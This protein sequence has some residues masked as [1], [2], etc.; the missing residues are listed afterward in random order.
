MG[1]GAVAVGEVGSV[2]FSVQFS[3]QCAVGSDVVM[4]LVAFVVGCELRRSQRY[5]GEKTAPDTCVIINN[6]ISSHLIIFFVCRYH[7]RI[8]AG[9]L[10]R[11][12]LVA[13]T[14]HNCKET[15]TCMV[16]M[17]RICIWHML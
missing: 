12:V 8:D 13:C 2:Q 16:A 6:T 7:P 4:Q 10:P 17:I 15:I 3:V 5:K 1:S 14:V 11:S 9:F